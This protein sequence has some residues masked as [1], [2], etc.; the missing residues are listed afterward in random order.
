[1]NKLIAI[2]T[3]GALCAT[4]AVAEDRS[5]VECVM[6]ADVALPALRNA[7]AARNIEV[8]DVVPPDRTLDRYVSRLI[9]TS[10]RR[11]S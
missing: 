10:A 1:M 11:T 8:F 2:A 6:A 4:A 3:L 9:L 5:P 7:L